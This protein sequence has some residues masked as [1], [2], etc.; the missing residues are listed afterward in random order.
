VDHRDAASEVIIAA[1]KQ[2]EAWMSPIGGGADAAV[3]ACIQRARAV[4]RADPEMS[5]ALTRL[6]VAAAGHLDDKPA[7]LLLRSNAW[8]EH[9]ESLAFV[10]LHDEAMGAVMTAHEHL[11]SAGSPPFDHARLILTHANVLQQVRRGLEVIFQVREAAKIF[12]GLGEKQQFVNARMIEAVIL[13]QAGRAAEALAVWR[14]LARDLGEDTDVKSAAAFG[15]M[16]STIAI[17][18]RMLGDFAG[19]RAY[20][21]RARERF[22]SC[23]QTADAVKSEWGVAK[24]LMAEGDLRGA[25]ELLQRVATQFAALS[26][27]LDEA[28]CELDRVDVLLALDRG[29]EARRVSRRIMRAF[30]DAGMNREV[31]RALANLQE[32]FVRRSPEGIRQAVIPHVRQFIEASKT[33][34]AVRYEPPL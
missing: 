33:R 30:E 3:S 24:V 26:M 5:L 20:Y 7:S 15:V 23:G 29:R 14:D 11:A 8:R 22:T 28:L 27:R 2:A 34:A 21:L 25:C 6:A 19:A 18:F 4:A 31:L 10:G 12:L 17:S 9:A 1:L 13:N 16:F 32:S